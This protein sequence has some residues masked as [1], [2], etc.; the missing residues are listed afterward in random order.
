MDTMDDDDNGATHGNVVAHSSRENCP[1]VSLSSPPTGAHHAHHAHPATTTHSRPTNNQLLYRAHF[2]WKHYTAPLVDGCELPVGTEACASVTSAFLQILST[3]H[4]V[5]SCRS[6]NPRN[7]LRILSTNTRRTKVV[8]M[9]S[10]THRVADDLRRHSL[11]DG[12]GG[13]YGT[14]LDRNR[15]GSDN[16]YL[17]TVT[18]YN[19]ESLGLCSCL[20]D[21]EIVDT[22]NGN[23]SNVVSVGP[24][25]CRCDDPSRAALQDS[26]FLALKAP[27]V[28]GGKRGKNSSGKKSG[29]TKCGRRRRETTR[30]TMSEVDK[31][32]KNTKR[33]GADQ[34]NVHT[35]LLGSTDAD[36]YDYSTMS[37]KYLRVDR[38]GER[39]KRRRS[40]V[41]MKKSASF[42]SGSELFDALLMA[43]ADDED[44]DDGG[45][46]SNLLPRSRSSRGV[47]PSERNTTTTTTT[48]IKNTNTNALLLQ[49]LQSLQSQLKD[50]KLPSAHK[51]GL[52]SERKKRGSY[53]NLNQSFSNFSN[54]SNGNLQH[55]GA[56]DVMTSPM[57]FE[58][59][60]RDHQRDHHT[61]SA[62]RP[63]LRRNS[64]S[65]I[66]NNPVLAQTG[67][68]DSLLIDDGLDDDIVENVENVDNVDGVGQCRWCWTQYWK[69][70][71]Y[72][73][74][75]YQHHHQQ[76]HET[77]VV[78]GQL[79]ECR[80][81]G[82]GPGQERKAPGIRGPAAAHGATQAGAGARGEQERPHAG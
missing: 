18:R 55:C 40:G 23:E 36:Y 32:D 53:N 19:L 77:H 49:S 2:R 16:N 34:D 68:G 54:F 5:E 62:R 59:H 10:G 58:D 7:V 56:N 57:L 82:R 66:L 47:G 63:M 71:E 13:Q 50:V 15:Y 72:E 27:G 11:S 69:Q 8:E 43:T 12:Q 17:F 6:S 41:S 81:C 9:S 28:D 1:L 80:A 75:E 51:L 14:N 30:E 29:G 33:R 70:Y 44:D 46:E 20:V 76:Q 64:V 45:E 79:G 35:F 21:I 48:T 37:E 3:I 73:Q 52:R 39:E 78:G 42:N 22:R 4:A 26:M 60:Q 31:M 65:M 67:A 24:G 25:A 74:H 61:S 38:E